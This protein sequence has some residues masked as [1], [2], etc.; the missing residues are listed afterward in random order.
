M[1]TL[2]DADVK[3][4]GEEVTIDVVYPRTANSGPSEGY[5]DWFQVRAQRRLTFGD[6]GQFSFR[7]V[8]SMGHA[9]GRFQLEN[10]LPVH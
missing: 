8:G 7:D 2:V 5:L 4:P 10:H 9:T 1:P 6:L 3:L